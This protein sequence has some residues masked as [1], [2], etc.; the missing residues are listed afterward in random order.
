MAA[1]KSPYFVYSAPASLGSSIVSPDTHPAFPFLD[2]LVEIRLRVLAFTEMKTLRVLISG[3]LASHEVK[4]FVDANTITILK[5]IVRERYSLF[6]R[7]LLRAVLKWN[8][9]PREC[10]LTLEEMLNGLT[11]QTAFKEHRLSESTGI[12]DALGIVMMLGDPDPDPDHDL[13]SFILS[14]DRFGI[15]TIH[16]YHEW[17]SN[18]KNYPRFTT[19]FLRKSALNIRIIPSRVGGQAILWEPV[20]VSCDATS[21]ISEDLTDPP[22][23][24]NVT[25]AFGVWNRFLM[26][27]FD[28]C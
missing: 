27:L 15:C 17:Y 23:G 6:E 16:N 14:E 20:T 13:D 9:F 24:T 2:L 8:M 12:S 21:F 10:D 28:C 7:Q 22:G 18:S 3:R 19:G 4:E 25:Y 11:S 1:S 26:L 5:C